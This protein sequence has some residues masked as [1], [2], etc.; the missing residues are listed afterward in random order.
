MSGIEE[1]GHDK[2]FARKEVLFRPLEV[3][4]FAE[5]GLRKYYHGVEDWLTSS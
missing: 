3:A 1:I 4:F 5:D 2:F